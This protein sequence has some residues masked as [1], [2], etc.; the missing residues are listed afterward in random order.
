M[1]REWGERRRARSDAPVAR[2]SA[3]G[4]FGG[5]GAGGA[6][7]G[8]AGA[9]SLE[10][11]SLGAS[12]ICESLGMTGDGRR[13][14]RQAGG[15][16]QRSGGERVAVVSSTGVGRAHRIACSNLLIGPCQIYAG[17]G[18]M[19]LASALQ[20]AAD[21]LQVRRSVALTPS[22]QAYR[23]PLQCKPR[24]LSTTPQILRS[25]PGA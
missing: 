4:G 17:P 16:A 8:L 25:A 24:P 21:S 1:E 2:T 9:A 7:A 22:R 10:D 23:L 15:V 11:W 12:V 3:G 14:R 5:G 20:H 13:R 6:A 18:P 19:H